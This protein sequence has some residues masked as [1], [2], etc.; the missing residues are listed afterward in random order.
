M[1]NF[2]FLRCKR[3]TSIAFIL[4]LTQ[5]LISCTTYEISPFD[6]PD[7]YCDQHLSE[8]VGPTPI[9]AEFEVIPLEDWQ[10]VFA[11][12][13]LGGKRVIAFDNELTLL[14]ADRRKFYNEFLFFKWVAGSTVVIVFDLNS[15]TDAVK[16]A[17]KDI[18]IKYPE[19]EFIRL[20]MRDVRVLPVSPWLVRRNVI[21]PCKGMPMKL[22]PIQ[23]VLNREETLSF[24]G[25]EDKSFVLG[26]TVSFYDVTS[27]HYFNKTF[28]IRKSSIAVRK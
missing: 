11:I 26:G 23:F 2:L 24:E 20:W 28:S 25:L 16:N 5:L 8:S 13:E 18:T 22:L 15:E 12:K 4:I 7:K 10:S 21:T 17:K 9:G 19:A 1:T 6:L 27:E 3:S 14:S